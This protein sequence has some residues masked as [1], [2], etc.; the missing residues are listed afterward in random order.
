MGIRFY[1][2]ANR[3]SSPHCIYRKKVYLASLSMPRSTHTLQ[4]NRF[5]TS[6]SLA[7][8]NPELKEMGPPFEMPPNP[9]IQITHFNSK[10][11][12]SSA[13]PLVPDETQDLEQGDT[14]LRTLQELRGQMLTDASS[15][16]AELVTHKHADKAIENTELASDEHLADVSLALKTQIDPQTVLE[17]KAPEGVE[18][19]ETYRKG[20]LTSQVRDNIVS[21]VTQ[22]QAD[23]AGFLTALT[24]LDDTQ[25]KSQPRL[26]QILPP[27]MEIHEFAGVRDSRK[28]S[29]LESQSECITSI[30]EETVPYLQS[31]PERSSPTAQTP[32]KKGSRG[33]PRLEANRAELA[34]ETTKEC[35]GSR[36][37]SIG[38]FVRSDSMLIEKNLPPYLES[39]NEHLARRSLRAKSRKRRQEK[40][41][42]RG[43]TPERSENTTERLLR[44]QLEG[45]SIQKRISTV[46]EVASTEA[47]P[48]KETQTGP[49][50]FE[51]MASKRA[52][53]ALMPRPELYPPPPMVILEDVIQALENIIDYQFKDPYYGWH[54]LQ[55]TAYDVEFGNRRLALLGDSLLRTELITRW[56]ATGTSLGETS[57]RK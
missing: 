13:L 56:L 54:A 8:S 3:L 16:K 34:E 33:Q 20:E 19:Y 23:E 50:V 29:L 48:L 11:S 4:A 43:E 5:T 14:Q 32:N 6:S 21:E 38:E 36:I 25:D 53:G 45:E 49:H 41:E 15:E 42:S 9:K 46:K 52:R 2:S 26:E 44:G 24:D 27:E 39:G 31:A 12:N 1:V 17:P 35:D 7:S 40:L 10:N 22:S 37:E 55:G 47:H 51:S 57:S 28:G 30:F 18:E